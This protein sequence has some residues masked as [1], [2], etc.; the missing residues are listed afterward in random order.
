VR[1]IKPRCVVLGVTASIAAYKA[2]DIVRRLREAGCDVRVVMSPEACELIQPLV[3]RVLSGNQVYQGL[4]DSPETWDVE[5]VSLAEEASLVL[6]AP[7]TANCI[8]KISAGIC[9]DMLTCVVAATRAP[10]LL[11]PAMNENMY[12][13]RI[14]QE[15]IKRLKSLGY[16]FIGPQTGR[17]AC[18]KVGTGCLSDVDVIV[19]QALKAL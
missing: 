1:K 10:V 12:R 11:C 6:I 9:D 4:F 15:N 14:T 8:A 3:F 19:K 5:H 16:G 7:A 2:C 13:N 17:L 18:G